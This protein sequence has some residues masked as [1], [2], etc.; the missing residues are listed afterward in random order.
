MQGNRGRDTRAELAVRRLV[1]AQ[2]LRYRVN[3][4]PEADLRRTADLLFTRLKVAV[5]VDGCYWHG[6]P[7]HFTLPVT[8]VDYWSSKIARN[9]ARDKETTDVLQGRGWRVLRFWE[10]ETPES[11]AQRIG[12]AVRARRVAVRP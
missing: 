9:R 12:E 3:A 4:R 5:F 1:H 8:N 6:C 7:A 10:H 2:G 11:V